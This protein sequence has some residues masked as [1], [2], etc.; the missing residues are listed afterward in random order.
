MQTGH[1]LLTEC[2]WELFVIQGTVLHEDITAIPA[3]VSW[4]GFLAPGARDHNG[5]P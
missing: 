4:L 2:I 5:R 1:V 3:A